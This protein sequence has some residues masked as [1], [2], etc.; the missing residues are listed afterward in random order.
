MEQNIKPI[1]VDDAINQ[2]FPY[3]R[4][5]SI[6]SKDRAKY[7]W[8]KEA[9]TAGAQWQK[10]HTNELIRVARI[11][12]DVLRETDGP[13]LAKELENAIKIIVS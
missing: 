2:Y 7:E 5:A 1:T 8:A 11:A 13:L 12:I 10:E 9:F 3:G 6:G 4:S